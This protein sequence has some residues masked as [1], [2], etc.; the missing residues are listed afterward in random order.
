MKEDLEV[1]GSDFQKKLYEK[2][3]LQKEKKYHE[4]IICAFEYVLDHC[5]L[6]DDDILKIGER[7]EKSKNRIDDVDVRIKNI[8][9]KHL[10]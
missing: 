5:D 3:R 4:G 1:P 6:Y 9:A 8:T 2:R 7:I 10:K